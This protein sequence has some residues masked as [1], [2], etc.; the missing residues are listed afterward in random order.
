MEIESTLLHLHD[1]AVYIAEAESCGFRDEYAAQ[2]KACAACVDT[3]DW[4]ECLDAFGARTVGNFVADWCDG[5]EYHPHD[6]SGLAYLDIG[7]GNSL[8]AYWTDAGHWSVDIE[9]EDRARM[10]AED[11]ARDW[12]EEEES[13]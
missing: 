13:L 8:V 7:D 11:I 9:T 4:Q 1:V 12:Y 3:A 6:S 5:A 2:E 10:A